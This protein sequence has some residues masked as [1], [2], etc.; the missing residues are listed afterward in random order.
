MAKSKNVAI[1][2]GAGLSIA[3]GIPSFKDKDFW[4]KPDSYGGLSAPR[5]IQMNQFFRKHPNLC[6]QWHMDFIKLIQEQDI[7]PNMGH[8]LIKEFQEYCIETAKTESNDDSKV[9]AVL[10]TENYDD[11]HGKLIRESQVL[12]DD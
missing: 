3:S 2:T 8:R 11:L 1:L 9:T 12:M 10:I 4:D 6:W 5:E 7:Q